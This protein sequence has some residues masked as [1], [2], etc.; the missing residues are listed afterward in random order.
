MAINKIFMGQPI[1]KPGYYGD[2]RDLDP[3]NTR[4]ETPTIPYETQEAIVDALI[5][6]D[7][8]L[9]LFDFLKFNPAGGFIRQEACLDPLQ[10]CPLKVVYKMRP[11]V[12]LP[13]LK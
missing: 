4:K 6:L 7:H 13:R 8:M 10:P 5:A 12:G 2:P 1:Y 11:G 9:D 3:T